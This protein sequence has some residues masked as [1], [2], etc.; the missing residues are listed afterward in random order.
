GRTAGA[1]TGEVMM[2]S[3]LSHAPREL[4]RLLC[5]AEA[6]GRAFD[7]GLLPKRGQLA[8]PFGQRAAALLTMAGLLEFPADPNVV[9]TV[10]ALALDV[11]RLP[12][13]SRSVV[14]ACFSSK[15]HDDD[16]YFGSLADIEELERAL[17][18]ADPVA[19]QRMSVDD[20]AVGRLGALAISS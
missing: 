20:A 4:K 15:D 3:F 5:A 14:R 12:P 11:L 18:R 8:S 16:D 19:L 1:L 6:M 2:H 7:L 9:D 17:K 13:I 10:W